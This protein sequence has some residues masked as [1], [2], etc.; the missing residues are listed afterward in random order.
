MF[1]IYVASK[2]RSDILSQPQETA[3][4]IVSKSRE[5]IV[6]NLENTFSS[7][8]EYVVFDNSVLVICITM[9]DTNFSIKV[10]DFLAWN[11]FADSIE[12]SDKFSTSLPQLHTWVACTI[13][14]KN[15]DDKTVFLDI[16]NTSYELQNHCDV[17]GQGYI[18]T[19]NIEHL[20][21]KCYADYDENLLEEDELSFDSKY[22]TIDLEDVL[23]QE[24]QLRDEIKKMCKTCEES[25]NS[26]VLET[27]E[28]NNIKRVYTQ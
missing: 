4:K 20:F 18:Q 24:I 10:N 8:E 21:L 6:V 19:K 22:A 12:F 9:K 17:C 11:A 1:W 14:I 2:Y 27:P 13:S 16:Y 23:V 15:G 7:K 25:S 26:Q 3:T 5:S 28:Q